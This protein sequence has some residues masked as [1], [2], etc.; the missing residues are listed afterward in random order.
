M[1]EPKC[2]LHASDAQLEL[3]VSGYTLAYAVLLITSA[4]LGGTRGYR[5]MF[6]LGLTVFTPASLAC[7]LAPTPVL[8]VVARVVQGV[9]AALLTS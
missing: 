1:R 2:H 4:R 5:R 8:L 6:Q 9:G 3:I 7:G